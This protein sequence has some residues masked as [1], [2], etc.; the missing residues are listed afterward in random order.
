MLLD[1]DSAEVASSESADVVIVG[2]GAAGITLATRLADRGARIIV[3]ESGALEPDGTTQSLYDMEV[4][5]LPLSPTRSRLRYFGGTTN[6]WS[7]WC[8]QMDPVDIQPV[9]A[10]GVAGWPI[11]HADIA[12]YYEAAHDYCGIGPLLQRAEDYVGHV[13]PDAMNEA[14]TAFGTQPVTVV[15]SR[16]IESRIWQYSAPVRFGTAHRG[17]L[18]GS[19]Q[20]RVFLRLNLIGATFR[21]NQI[22]SIRCRTL[23]GKDVVITGKVTVLCCGGIENA[24]ILLTLNGPDAPQPGNSSDTVG[25]YFAD[26]VIPT[27]VCDVIPTNGSFRFYAG[28]WSSDLTRRGSGEPLRVRALFALTEAAG[29]ELGVPHISA[30]LDPPAP[31]DPADT[32]ALA[33]AQYAVAY[34]AQETGL[35]PRDRLER[36]ACVLLFNHRPAHSSRVYLTAMRDPLGLPRAGIDWRIDEEAD[37]KT[38][39]AFAGALGTTLARQHLGRVRWRMQGS[40]GDYVRNG[41][42]TGKHHCGTTRMAASE[43]DGVVDRDLRVFGVHNL[44]VCGSSVF[45]RSTAS[46]PT[47]TIVALAARLAVHLQGVLGSSTT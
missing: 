42:A 6:H 20:V 33:A 43:R 12:P 16:E 26:H 10:D 21:D 47:P 36:M 11:T 32:E 27:A 23:K 28:R 8:R 34:D 5:G 37:L 24:R 30:R 31:I 9:A 14:R 2:A 13:G 44:Y 46:T 18:Q 3:V 19:S 1:A 40:L 22:A 29:K 15:A 38:M 45:P 17:A 7:G 39:R 35:R 25:R 41:G 4:S